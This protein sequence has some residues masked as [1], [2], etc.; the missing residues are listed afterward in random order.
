MDAWAAARGGRRE[1]GAGIADG[2]AGGVEQAFAG[3]RGGS[4]TRVVAPGGE[5]EALLPGE[6]KQLQQE[7]AAMREYLQSVIEEQES[8]NE[9]L[10]SAN[11]EILSAN[12]ELQTAKEEAQS[13]NEELATVNEELQHRNADLAR[14]NNDLINLLSGVHIPIV[15]VNRDLG[16]RR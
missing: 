10:T 4:V 16:I 7:L 11:E 12:E 5:V 2:S 1:I 13:A 3:D 6:Q 8:T 14:V 9:E 15:M